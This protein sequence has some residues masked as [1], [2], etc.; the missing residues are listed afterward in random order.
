MNDDNSAINDIISQINNILSLP[1][2]SPASIP[3]DLAL[4]STNRQGLSVTKIFTTFLQGKQKMGLPV[5]TLPNGDINKDDL[6][7]FLVIQS[8]IN[9]IKFDAKIQ[10]AI[11]PGGALEASGVAGV[12]PCE[13]AGFTIDIQ[14]GGGII[15]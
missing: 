14:T 2:S 4:L 7:W 13:V 1:T 6:C 11:E 10:V 5:G 3:A 12:I 9:A 8:I 15:Q